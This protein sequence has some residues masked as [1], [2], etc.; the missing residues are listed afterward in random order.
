MKRYLFFLAT[1]ISFLAHG[2][3][4]NMQLSGEVLDFH[5]RQPL[6]GALIRISDTDLYAVSDID[7]KYII[8]ELCNGTYTL[9]VSHP[10]CRSKYI[11]VS[12]F[13]NTYKRLTLE[14]HIMELDEVSVVGNRNNR[15]TNSGQEVALQKNILERYA[16]A[17]LSDALKE[18]SGVSTLNTGSNIVKPVIQ[19]LNGSRVLIMNNGVRMQD[20]EWGDEHAPNID[21]NAAGRATV[22]KGAS[23][24][25]Y[26]GDAVGG[27]I[28][29]EPLKVQASDTLFGSTLISGRT[30][31]RGGIITSNLTKSY[32][33]GWF[34]KAQASYKRF[35]D[36][37]APDYIL[38]NTGVQ[39]KAFSLGFG[40][41]D[42]YKGWDVYY[43]FYDA[44][45]AVLASSHIGNVDDL[46]RAINSGQPETI[47]DF[48]YDIGRPSQEVTHHLG[49][50]RYFKRFEG[51]GK[52]SVQYDFQ[53]NQRFEFDVRVGDDRNKP[54]IDLELTTHT[55]TTDISIDKSDDFLVKAG[56]LG[57]FQD[58]FADPSTGVRRL[59]PDYERYDFGAYLLG[60][61]YVTDQL[62]IDAGIRYDLNY[63]DAKKFYRTSRWEERGYD[64]DFEA[65]VLEDLGTQLLTNPT[66]TFHN[67]S[68]TLGGKYA[69]AT[70]ENIRV[71]YALSQRA[72]NPAELFSDGLH[73]SAARIELGDLRSEQETSHKFSV[74]LNRELKDF[75][76]QISPY[77]NYINNFL[78]LE[79]TGVEFTIRG[80]FPVWEYRQINARLLGID[81]SAAYQWNGNIS[82]NHRFSFVKGN[83][84]DKDVPLFNIP[85]VNTVNS[86]VYTNP[87][88]NNF[89][90]GIES[91]FFFEQNETPDNILVFSP[92]AGGEVLLRINDADPSYH[93][94]NIW[95]GI[96]VS[97]F[98]DNDLSLGFTINNLLNEN[99]RNYL[100][101]LR[102]FADDVGRNIG[103]SIK[104]NY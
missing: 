85:Q 101:R 9:E 45:I 86:L 94:L 81:A 97:L 49:R 103:F 62:T 69:F 2:Q 10:E 38:S 16:G 56:L 61:Y 96:D 104:L 25:Q 64:E 89:S 71:N 92:D 26:G 3:N 70:G 24:L 72:P 35:G 22:I 21:I 14:H 43:S 7:G 63:I 34:A 27:V 91:Q 33:S 78:Q 52:W 4:C 46:I 39:E 42:F 29:L 99:F 11:P 44:D 31:G 73:H 87:K 36:G 59:I 28:V 58:N 102:N 37:E 82:T 17:T 98:A 15:Q 80:A 32:E 30:N 6:V 74:S 40:K 100:N 67:F 68:G 18:V 47:R 75:T 13:G 8:K 84:L 65:I 48:T 54:A 41:R 76:W 23:A 50:L 53:H 19:G 90:L 57:R 20:M 83:D 88:W 66:F 1:S 51:F 77:A 55:L 79:S 93:V 60:D 5:D 12:V 95:G